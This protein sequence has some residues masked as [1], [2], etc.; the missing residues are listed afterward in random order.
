MTEVDHR[1]PDPKNN[2][3]TRSYNSEHGP[4]FLY[5]ET[6]TRVRIRF[7]NVQI[8]ESFRFLKSSSYDV[9][10]RGISSF[11]TEMLFSAGH[12]PVDF[13]LLLK[14]DKNNSHRMLHKQL[15]L[16]FRESEREV[17][18]TAVR[19]SLLFASYTSKP[20]ESF[21][22]V[23]SFILAPTVQTAV[24]IR[25]A[26]SKTMRV[27]QLRADWVPAAQVNVS[28]MAS[29]PAI[30]ADKIVA[31][32]ITWT[33]EI[34]Q[35]EAVV[36]KDEFLLELEGKVHRVKGKVAALTAHE[37]TLEQQQDLN[38][39]LSACEELT[40]MLTKVTLFNVETVRKSLLEAV[41]TPLQQIINKVEQL[42]TE[43][44]GSLMKDMQR[45]ADYFTMRDNRLN[46]K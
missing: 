2:N 37:L 20:V 27:L 39:L 26:Y 29:D 22:S 10:I 13:L 19:D 36:L 42:E 24:R 46:L 11:I 38:I 40:G 43:V 16:M 6:D 21:T 12:E 8:G 18:I 32:E 7:Q 15:A 5:K 9:L 44:A 30:V 28:G 17:R 35:H 4:I 33:P 23:R 1:K 45:L 31:D 41:E 14:E 34:R 25:M 3:L